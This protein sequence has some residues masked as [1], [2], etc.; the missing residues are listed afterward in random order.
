[1]RSVVVTGPGEVAVVDV[2]TPHAGPRDI[3]VKVRANGICGSDSFYIARGGVPPREGATPLEH[4]PASAVIEAGDQV[5][6]IAPGDHVGYR[7]GRGF[8]PLRGRP[9][10]D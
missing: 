2:A 10:R 3:V 8:R 6:D 4:E 1:M 7:P 5:R 9:A